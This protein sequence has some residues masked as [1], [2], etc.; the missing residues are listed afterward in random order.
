MR[1]VQQQSV[2]VQYPAMSLKE[3]QKVS[4]MLDTNYIVAL[5]NTQEDFTAFAGMDLVLTSHLSFF[6]VIRF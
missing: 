4:E 3:A 6:Y 5:V 1:L 2:L